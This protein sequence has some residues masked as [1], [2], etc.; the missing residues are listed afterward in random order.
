[1]NKKYIKGIMAVALAALF[2]GGSVVFA[3]PVTRELHFGVSINIDGQPLITEDDAAPFI[4][5]GRTYVPIRAIAEA[6]GLDVDFIDGEIW[7]TSQLVSDALPDYQTSYDLE[8]QDNGNRFEAT[9]DQILEEKNTRNGLTDNDTFVPGTYTGFMRD[10][11]G[12]VGALSYY[13]DTGAQVSVTMSFTENEITSV[14]INSHMETGEEPTEE[15]NAILEQQVLEAQSLN[16]EGIAELPYTTENFI[17]AVENTILI[18]TTRHEPVNS[19]VQA[20]TGFERNLGD[21]V[22]FVTVDGRNDTLTIGV[23][24]ES[25]VIVRATIIHRDTRYVVDDAVAQFANDIV[26]YQ[27]EN[28]DVISGATNTSVAV[29]EA[30]EEILELANNN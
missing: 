18:A 8:L 2:L 7:I 4:I 25:G 13:H 3:N 20:I 1:M 11:K 22:H 16:I 9:S 30:V 19:S 23:E 14:T 15:Q 10:Y 5:N 26:R 12:G 21:G 27:L 24:I 28:I 17:G 6:L 29:I